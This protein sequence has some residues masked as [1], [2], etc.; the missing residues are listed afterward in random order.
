MNEI[1]TKYL[2]TEDKSMPK[3]H[4]RQPVFT[5]SACGPFTED[6]KRIRNFKE[7]GE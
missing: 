5:H 7:T 2:L 1:V 3:M 6:K 4:L